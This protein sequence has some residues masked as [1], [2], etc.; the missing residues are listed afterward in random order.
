MIKVYEKMEGYCQQFQQYWK[1]WKENTPLFWIQLKFQWFNFKEYLK[2]IFFYYRNLSF[3]KSDTL[4]LLSYLFQNPY[5][6]NKEFLKKRGEEVVDVYG[7]TP[8]TT[9]EEIVSKCQITPKDNFYE[10]GAGR[11]RTCFWLHSFIG[12]KVIGLEI[13]PQFVTIANQIVEKKHLKNIHFENVNFLNYDCKDATVIYLYGICLKDE[14]LVQLI[15][16]LKK[17]PQGTKFITISF[18]LTEY[19]QEPLFEVTSCF[20]GRFPWGIADVYLQYRK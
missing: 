19:T 1:Q 13:I 11:G 3:L 16:Q 8:L 10:L 14:D 5:R 4:L 17:L 7:E 18:P 20:Q 9:F 12:C 6:M 2:V 15:Q